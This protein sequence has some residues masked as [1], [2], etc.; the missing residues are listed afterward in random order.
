MA[1]IGRAGGTQRDC[2]L[3]LSASGKGLLYL[4]RSESSNDSQ[5]GSSLSFIAV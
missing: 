4:V 3:Q 2:R 5:L 1:S